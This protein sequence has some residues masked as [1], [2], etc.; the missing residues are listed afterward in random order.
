MVNPCHVPQKHVI[1]TRRRN[2]FSFFGKGR[3]P[4]RSPHPTPLPA[5]L[6]RAP[7]PKERPSLFPSRSPSHHHCTRV[8]TVPIL[9]CILTMARTGYAKGANSGHVTE[10]R[11]LKPKPSSRKGVSTFCTVLDMCCPLCVCEEE[12]LPLAVQGRS[13]VPIDPS[14]A[15]RLHGSPTLFYACCRHPR[16]GCVWLGA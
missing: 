1:S 2:Y 10:Q 8:C 11:D 16:T 12:E 4:S 5:C 14:K 15:R 9:H 7:P 3:C 6:P 13:V